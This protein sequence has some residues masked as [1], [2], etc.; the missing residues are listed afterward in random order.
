[1]FFGADVSIEEVFGHYEKQ[2]QLSNKNRYNSLVQDP[3]NNIRQ[4]FLQV[5]HTTSSQERPSIA[6]VVGSRDPTNSL[7]AARLSERKCIPRWNS[8]V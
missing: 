8:D 2:Y 3:I 7:Y 5:T 6:A 1:M 4:Y